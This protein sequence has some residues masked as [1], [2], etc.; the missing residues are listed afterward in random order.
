MRAAGFS[1]Q[2]ITFAVLQLGVFLSLIAFSLG[3]W[4]IPIT[5][6]Y[7]TNF[8]ATQTSNK[9]TITKDRALWVKEKK[10][11]IHI[12]TVLSRERLAGITIYRIDDAHQKL[13]DLTTIESARYIDEKWEL[14]KVVTRIFKEKQVLIDRVDKAYVTVL[15]SPDVL[16]VTAADPE[17]LSSQQLNKLIQHQQKNGLSSDKLELAFWKHYSIPLSALVMLLLAMPFLFSSQRSA[18]TGQRIFIG[19]VVG[20][21]F[22]LLNSVLNELGTVYNVLPIASAFFP[23]LLF[24]VVSLFALKR[25]T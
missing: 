7:A 25:V 15:I 8:K 23:V 1:I 4:V 19:I 12:N 16:E 2:R 24:L 10:K 17:K 22:F 14:N 11:F 3:E 18:N 9:V 13:S 6:R 20:I 5:D 21:I